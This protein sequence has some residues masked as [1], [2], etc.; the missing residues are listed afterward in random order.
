M[1]PAETVASVVSVLTDSFS[2]THDLLDKLL[3]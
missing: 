2:Q 3:P 1:V